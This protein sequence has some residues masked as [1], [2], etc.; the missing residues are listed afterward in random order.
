[1]K[2]TLIQSAILNLLQL[3]QNMGHLYFIR[4]NSGAVVNQQG[5]FIRMGRRGSSDIIVFFKGGSTEFWEVKNEKGKLNANQIEFRDYVTELGYKYHILRSV[6][7]A[8]E[9]LKAHD[10]GQ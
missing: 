10:Y 8:E 2:E 9:Q 6:D 1:M 7:D 5:R 4:N 3:H